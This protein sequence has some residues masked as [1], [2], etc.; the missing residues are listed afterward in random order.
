VANTTTHTVAPPPKATSFQGDTHE[1][2]HGHD[3]DDHHVLQHHFD[4]MEQQREATS[5]GMWTFLMTEIMMFSGLFFCY[6]LFRWKFHDAYMLGSQQL[7]I[8][9]GTINT[10]VLLASSMTMAMAV[11]YAQV[12]NR[13]KLVACMIGTLIFGGAF[14]GVKAVEW[15]ADYHEGLVPTNNLFGTGQRG[16]WNPTLW[17]T[18]HKAPQ[19][20]AE[21]V[22]KIKPDSLITYDFKHRVKLADGTD[23]PRPVSVQQVHMYFMLYFC[24]TGLHAVHMVAGAIILLVMLVMA[25]GGAFTNGNDQP[26]ELFGL[27]WHFVDIVWVFL[28]PLL[29]LIAGFHPFG[30]H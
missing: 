12:K 19:K 23:A 24:M 11:H 13:Q 25:M 3:H 8:Q 10:F 7:N 17:P 26:V 20:D 5:L 28:F 2:E 1:H 6:A 18:V 16:N 21:W 27:Y 30:G 4:D 29:Y 22:A 15:S 9:L 14:L